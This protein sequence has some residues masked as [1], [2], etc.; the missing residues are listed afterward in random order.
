MNRRLIGLMLFVIALFFT[1]NAQRLS[2]KA[3]ISVL[4]V[5]PGDELY[6]KFGHS[7]IRVYD[8]V[9]HIDWVFNY[10]TFDFNTPH[11]YFKFIKGRLNYMLSVQT[12]QG[13]QWSYAQENR[14]VDEQVL[15]LSQWQKQKVYDFLVW[16]AQPANRYYLYDFFFDNCATRVRDVFFDRL[17]DSLVFDNERLN[18][19]FRQAFNRYMEGNPWVLFGENLIVGSIADRKLDAW[20]AMFLPDY[21]EYYFDRIKIKT[22]AGLKPIVKAKSRI[23]KAN[24]KMSHFPWYS[25]WVIFSVLALLLLY[26]EIV[27]LKRGK[28]IRWIDFIL[29]F[30]LG[31]AGVVIVLLWGFTDHLAAKNNF[32][33]IWAFPLHLIYAFY[34]L[35]RRLPAWVK[36]YSKIFL[37]LMSIVLGIYIIGFLFNFWII[38]QRVDYGVIPL[39]VIVISRLYVII[40]ND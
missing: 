13:F 36:V 2:T 16:N 22:D 7:A 27:E 31:L 14:W 35:K 38:P 20:H 40:R 19:T 1:S 30:V 8:P 15:D 11:F 34:L 9:R 28:R 29:F 24:R 4:T 17:K 23:I 10:G 3:R 39:L 25:P 33:V 21:L 5:S 6:S 26:V 32:N 18:L 12:F 37:Y